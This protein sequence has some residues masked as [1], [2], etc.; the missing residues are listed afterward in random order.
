MDCPSEAQLLR[1]IG[2]ERGTEALAAH[3]TVCPGCARRV[4]E[5]REVWR[6]LA[7]ADVAPPPLN[8]AA[9]VLAAAPRSNQARQSAGWGRLAAAIVL[10]CGVGLSAALLG[11]SQARP[12][13][14]VSGEQ[15]A[16]Q[17]GLDELCSDDELIAALLASE[18]MPADQ[19]EVAS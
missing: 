8:L 17:L 16:G 1:L 2:G 11:G 7:D 3:L 10:G 18:L 9:R 14:P 4:G 6:V 5:L 15:L 13:A 12:Q 19:Q